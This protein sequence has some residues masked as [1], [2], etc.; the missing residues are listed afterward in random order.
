EIK[1]L[2][3]P[4]TFLLDLGNFVKLNGKILENVAIKNGNRILKVLNQVLP[5]YLDTLNFARVHFFDDE[6]D[7][8]D[9]LDLLMDTI[10]PK[11]LN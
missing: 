10:G 6:V 1:I 9:T 3:L 2:N 11:L 8:D 7:N 4:K 5:K